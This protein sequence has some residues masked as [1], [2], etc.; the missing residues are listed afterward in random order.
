MITPFRIEPSLPAASYKTYGIA[1]PISTHFRTGTCTEA[2][3]QAQAKGWTTSV[4][5]LTDLGQKQAHYIRKASGRKFTEAKDPS[6]LTVFTF[7]AGQTC[8]AAHKVLLDRPEFYFVR[9]GDWRGNPRGTPTLRHSSAD[10]WLND[11]G[12]HQDR[13]KRVIEG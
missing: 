11:F 5:E 2:D 10:S 4:D 9:E 7:E 6:G 13:L 3:C 8:F 12:V 1:S